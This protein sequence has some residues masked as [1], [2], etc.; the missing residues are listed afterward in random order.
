VPP[1]PEGVLLEPSLPGA[2]PADPS[3][4]VIATPESKPRSFVELPHP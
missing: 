1:S 2:F 4:P 3:S